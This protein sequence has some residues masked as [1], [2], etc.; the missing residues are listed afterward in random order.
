MVCEFMCLDCKRITE[1]YFIS[2]S[3]MVNAL[4]RNKIVCSSCGKNN[5][6]RLFGRSHIRTGE[7]SGYEKKNQGKITVGKAFDQAKSKWV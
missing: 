2:H 7:V 6:R 4:G 5:M 3:R 1:E